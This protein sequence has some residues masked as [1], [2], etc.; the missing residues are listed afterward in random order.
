MNLSEYVA[1][2]H[3]LLQSHPHIAL[4]H[5]EADFRGES[6]LY[7]SGKVEF[8]HGATLDFKEFLEFNN[9]H[10]QKYMYGY[11]YRT[12]ETVLFRYDNAPDPR[13]THLSTYPAHK[14]DGDQLIA[15]P[16]VDLPRVI[17]EIVERLSD[18]L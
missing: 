15:F 11:N 9:D 6:F 8:L 16:P 13:A 4:Y 12:S 7:L 2:L 10:I 3:S 17:N 14:H 18:G 1:D 5:L